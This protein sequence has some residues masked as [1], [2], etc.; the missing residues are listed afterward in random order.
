VLVAFIAI[1]FGAIDVTV[2]VPYWAWMLFATTLNAALA[3][4]ST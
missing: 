4:L 2:L 1:S 3:I